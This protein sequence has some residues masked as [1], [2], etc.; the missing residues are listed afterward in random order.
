[1]ARA[2]ARTSRASV[3]KL[4]SA[5]FQKSVSAARQ[6]P[7][8]T[9]AS[10]GWYSLDCHPQTSHGRCLESD[11]DNKTLPE[12][13]AMIETKKRTD[14]ALMAETHSAS[15]TSSYRAKRPIDSAPQDTMTMYTECGRTT[16]KCGRNRSG[17]LVNYKLCTDCF[18]ATRPKRPGRWGARGPASD[19]AAAVTQGGVFEVIG[20]IN[21]NASMGKHQAYDNMIFD[22]TLGWCAAESQQQPTLFLHGT[23]DEATYEHISTPAPSAWHTLT[24]CISDTGAQSCLMGLCILWRMGLWKKDLVPVQ[25]CLQVANN[26]EIQLLGTIFLKL[27]GMDDRGNLQESS[28][29]AYI[30]PS[31]D[32]LYLSRTAMEQLKVILPSF[33]RIGDA[34]TILQS[35]D[36]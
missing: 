4:T 1:M 29:M 28:V 32:K 36:P 19:S 2:C 12:T 23:V 31:T 10:N 21:N 35:E 16:P 30:S 14:Q 9:I 18:R 34:A 8:L 27:Q 24:A 22:G 33:P 20:G 7:T 11:I 17:K 13:I 25:C 26:E 15:V 3:G 5:A 6:F